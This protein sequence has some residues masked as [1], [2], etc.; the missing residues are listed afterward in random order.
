MKKIIALIALLASA[1]IFTGCGKDVP[2]TSSDFKAPTTAAS[3]T[4]ASTEGVSETSSET[5]TE[6]AESTAETSAPSSAERA[7]MSALAGYWYADGDYRHSWLHITADGR[8]ESYRPSGLKVEDGTVTYC[9]VD[10][11]GTMGYNFKSESYGSSMSF[12][13][14][15]EQLVPVTEY[16]QHY[17]KLYGEGGLGD[18]GRGADEKFVASDYVGNW[19][20]ERAYITIEDKG[21]GVFRA[22]VNWSSSAAAHV[23]WDYPLIFD[24]E[25]LVCDNA[26]TKTYIEFTSPDTEPES[27]VEA[28]NCSARFELRPDGLFWNDLTDH[29]ADFMIFIKY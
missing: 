8:Y 18:D 29:D 25:N 20:C 4:E 23:Q 19:G 11:S 21:E 3:S 1:A 5:A 12:T 27:T 9:S 15:G 7:D 10:G 6:A 2:E 16:D 22:V 24:G 26:G 13:L 28:E 14:D 17:Q